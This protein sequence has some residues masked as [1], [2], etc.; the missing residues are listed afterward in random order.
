MKL[1][2]VF[3]VKLLLLL[4]I[5]TMQVRGTPLYA[6][7]TKVQKALGRMIDSDGKFIGVLY[8][9]NLTAS[10]LMATDATG[11]IVS[12]PAASYP[13]PS[14]LAYVKGVTS[15]LQTQINAKAPSDGATLTNVTITSGT[16]PS[17]Q[18]LAGSGSTTI[19]VNENYTYEPQGTGKFILSGSGGADFS[20]LSDGVNLG[21]V[22]MTY[23]SMWNSV[24]KYPFYFT[25]CFINASG[26]ALDPFSGYGILSGTTV[27]V[28]GVE[29]HPGVLALTGTGSVNSGY[30]IRTTVDAILPSGGEFVVAIFSPVLNIATTRIGFFD[31][32]TVAAPSD[33]ACI[34]FP[35]TLT[36]WGYTSS[37]SVAGTTTTSYTTTAGTFYKALVKYNN[38]ASSVAF[39]LYD[40]AGA[41]LWTDSLSTNIGTVTGRELGVGIL[42]VSP[43]ATS[44]SCVKV[45]LLGLG[46]S[47]ELTR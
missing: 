13:L 9:S 19:G 14:E 44:D 8:P 42:S 40:E 41:V 30:A 47:K 45:D 12:L 33:S 6:F 5:T 10:E 32:T 22:S 2:K 26:A 11:N 39:T 25:E 43:N 31:T 21:N 36:A 34:S 20:G 38:T 35:G 4:V 17:H 28:P 37:N 15:A 16:M 18:T 46:F 3:T 23:S 24:L 29:N 27:S 1:R 7:S